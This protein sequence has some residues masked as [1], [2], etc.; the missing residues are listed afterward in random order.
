MS[1]FR[2]PRLGRSYQI[3]SAKAQVELKTADLANEEQKISLEAWESYQSLQTETENLKATDDLS[4]SATQSF[5]VAQGRYK[6]GVGTIIELL[7]AQSTLADSK[8]QRILALSNW[9]TAR[10]K[11]ASSLGKLG[12]WAI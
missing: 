6:K 9:R 4:Q 11:L 3:Q 12:F 5:N 2:Q 10:L 8:Q 1:L 7:N